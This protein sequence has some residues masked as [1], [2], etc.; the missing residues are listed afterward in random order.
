MISATDPGMH[1][2][3]GWRLAACSYGLVLGMATL[4]AAAPLERAEAITPVPADQ[5][6]PVIDFFRPRHFGY[7]QLNPAGTLVAT[8]TPGKNDSSSLVVLD[9]ATGKITGTRADATAEAKYDIYDV[10]WL[11]DHRLLFRLTQDKLYSYGLFS[12]DAETLHQPVPLNRFDAVIPIGIPD[13]DPL[14]PVV[15]LRQEAI[16]KGADGGVVQMDA[17]KNRDKND[18]GLITKRFPEPKGGVPEWYGADATGELAYALTMKNGVGTFHR[19]TNDGWQA[20]PINLDDYDVVGASDRPGELI[21]L[22]PADPKLGHPRALIRLDSVTGRPGDVIYRDENYDPDPVGLFMSRR[23][24]GPLLGIRVSH[25]RSKTVWLDPIYATL[26]NELNRTFP[27]ATV[28]II[29]ADRTDNQF[30]VF[31]YSDRV[32]GRYYHCQ[33]DPAKL[34]LLVDTKPWL[35]PKRQLPMQ[36]LAYKSR[37]GTPLEG[38]YTA[39]ATRSAA[40][41][42]LVVL[43]HGGPWV[44]DVWGWDP[45]VQFLASRGYAVFQPNYRGSSGYNWRFPKEDLWAFRKMHDDVTDGTRA[46][47]KAGLADPDR[48]AIMGGSFGGFLALCGAAYEGPLYRCAITMAGVFDWERLIRE[49]RYNPTDR[50]EYGILN[51]HLGDRKDQKARF[52]E[53]TPLNATDKITIPVFIAHGRKDWVVSASQSDRLVSALKKRDIPHETMFVSNETHGFRNLDNRVELY[54]RIEAFLARHLA[55][56]AAGVATAPPH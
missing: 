41:P 29:S 51:R 23:N 15:W 1:F 48:I 54:T 8:I 28:R 37:D 10:C 11:N 20:C 52:E 16:N 55:P 33:R 12:A 14:K 34:T 49:S 42:P 13:R 38:Y 25:K 21:A 50:S 47:I 43:P 22:E 44:R 7:P 45:E 17:T 18:L 4:S 2:H 39:P 3:F 9:L 26:Q 27:D 6:I 5:P 35:D 19:L 46:L 24:G 56:R 53:I 36:I 32:F 30:L 31:V 40:P